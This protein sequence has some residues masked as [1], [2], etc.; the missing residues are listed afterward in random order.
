MGQIADL[1]T[2]E[3]RKNEE[4]QRFVEDS[5]SDRQLLE[6]STRQI[7]D[8]ALAIARKKPAGF[9]NEMS[10]LR[11]ELS[12]QIEDL[13]QRLDA[14]K[15]KTGKI[16]PL[17]RIDREQ[18]IEETRVRFLLHHQERSNALSD[19]HS[20]VM[21]RAQ[22]DIGQREMAHGKNLA[23]IDQV[24]QTQ[25]DE[26]AKKFA[27]D[28][29][30]LLGER[31]QLAAEAQQLSE[32][33]L[34]LTNKPCPQCERKKDSVRMLLMKKE[35]LQARIQ[36]LLTDVQLHEEQMYRLFGTHRPQLAPAPEVT[37]PLAPRK[38][39]RSSTRA[40]SAMISS[41]TTTLRS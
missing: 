5:Q 29:E 18:S 30:S 25:R 11:S 24:C 10:Q 37:K 6:E 35:E 36:G 26:N 3:N 28:Y 41:K 20:Q 12:T 17:A 9:A 32:E 4:I 7:F 14:A 22:E 31:E 8:S 39:A 23:Q 38:A 16:I 34:F 13:K 27:E 2:L 1:Q 21:Q 15:A 19:R 33:L 40:Q